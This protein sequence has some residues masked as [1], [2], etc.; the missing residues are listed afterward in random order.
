MVGKWGY[1]IAFFVNS[2][3]NPG[4]ESIKFILGDKRLNVIYP[5]EILQLVLLIHEAELYY[6]RLKPVAS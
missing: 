3:R 2:A 1:W 5:Q 6:H 4:V